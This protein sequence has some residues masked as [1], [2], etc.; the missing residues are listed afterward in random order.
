MLGQGPAWHASRLACH[1]Q[2]HHCQI[3][4]GTHVL[5]VQCLLEG[6][7]MG[8]LFLRLVLCAGQLQEVRR[9]RGLCH[10]GPCQE[11]RQRGPQG[12]GRQR[13]RLIWL[14]RHV[15]T[16]S[17]GQARCSPLAAN[18]QD[19]GQIYLQMSVYAGGSRSLPLHWCALS[20]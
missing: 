19:D 9:R 8:G 20:P 10:P 6:T 15:S 4:Q 7:V 1:I 11:H 12:P 16:P 14:L 5:P 3:R 2:D 17:E 13:R 18:S